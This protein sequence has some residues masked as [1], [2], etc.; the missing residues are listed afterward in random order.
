[1]LCCKLFCVL[2]FV[3]IILLIIIINYYYYYYFLQLLQHLQEF[4]QRVLSRT[5]EIE[6]EVDGLVHEAKVLSYLYLDELIVG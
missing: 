6:Q 4:S 5:H 2:V 3:Y 1:M